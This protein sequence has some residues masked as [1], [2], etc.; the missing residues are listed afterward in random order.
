MDLVSAIV[1]FDQAKT[2]SSAQ[3]TVAAKVLDISKSQG[4]AAVQL[5]QAA[6]QEIDQASSNLVAATTGVGGQLNTYA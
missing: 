4:N 6:S 2:L 5:I 1:G 3:V